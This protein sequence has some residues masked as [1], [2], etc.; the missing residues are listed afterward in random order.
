MNKK[1][2]AVNGGKPVLE[3][4]PEDMFHWPIVTAEDEEAVC[5]VLRTGKMSGTDITKQFEKEY[6]AWTGA[7]YALATCN[8]TAALQE[9]LWA[10]GVCA[11]KEVIAPSMTYWASCACIITLGAEIN[12][13]DIQADTLC[14]D[15]D[16]IEHRINERT[17]A[18]MVVHYGGY[19]ADM[20]R[21]KYKSKMK[22]YYREAGIPVARYHL[23]DDLAGCLAFIQKVG[24]PVVVKP[25]NG[26]GANATY[27]I[28]DEYE[29][30]TFLSQ[31]LKGYIME[32]YV[33]GDVCSYDAIVDSSG[34]PVFE[35]GNVTPNSIMDVVNTHDNS[36]YYIVKELSPDVRKRGRDTLKSFGVRSR[37]VHFEFFRLTQD[38]HLGRKGEVVALEVNMR[39]CGGYSPDMMNF[40]NSVDVYKIW[41]DMI[42]FDH[43]NALPRG[44]K[45]FCAYMGRRD[46]KNFRMSHEYVMHEYGAN[47]RMVERIPPA[48]AP[49]M[50]DQMYVAVFPTEEALWKFYRDLSE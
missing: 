49:A 42:A 47:M 9:A 3:L 31:K 39:P 27:R 32:E 45:S 23:V 1:I 19:P 18:I 12:F 11:G 26:V 50:G 22:A 16:D 14:I 2:L 15:P 4:E 8:G 34:T 20:D 35:T 44:E 6:V 7:K 25:D 30:R 33:P 13:A 36:I 37:F 24:Y 5:A 29:L 21:I 41:A 17:T 46:G 28:S 38:C 40:A 43:V 48:L 10:C